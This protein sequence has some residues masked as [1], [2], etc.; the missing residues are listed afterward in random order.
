MGFIREDLKRGM[1]CKS[2]GVLDITLL[3]SSSEN[4]LYDEQ[5]VIT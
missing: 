3:S 1:V 5:Y 2:G 4:S